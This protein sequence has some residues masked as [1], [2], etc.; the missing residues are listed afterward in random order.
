MINRLTWDSTF[1]EI[2]IGE[3]IFQEHITYKNAD[4]FDLLY[5][6]SNNDFDISINNFDKTFSETKVVFSKTL[7]LLDASKSNI[8]SA[9]KISYKIEEIYELSYE[10]G[11]FSRFILD[12]NFKIEK[13]KELYKKWVDNSISKIF[14]DDLFVYQEENKT[15]G[16]VTF[17]VKNE[18]ATIGLIAVS[19][20]HQGK[21]IGSKLLNFLENYLFE[22]KISTLLIPTQKSN[23]AACNFYKKQGY[24]INDTTFIKHYWKKND[25]IQ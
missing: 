10:S 12:H 1:F 20:N 11:K 17:K 7:N 19:P 22:S 3:L 18:I 2:E 6:K 16:F 9:D 4:L 25:P 14:A 21:G 8:F 13:F 24:S 23:L 15:I 5:I